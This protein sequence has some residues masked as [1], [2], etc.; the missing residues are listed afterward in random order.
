MNPAAA[1]AELVRCAGTQFDPKGRGDAPPR[2]FGG[3]GGPL[4]ARDTHRLR[5]RKNQ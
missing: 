2:F 5:Q 4:A 1:A 3:G